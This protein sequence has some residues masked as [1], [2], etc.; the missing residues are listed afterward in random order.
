MGSQ[1][2]SVAAPQL[3]GFVL[4][5][6]GWIGSAIAAGL[7][8]W[9]V[10]HVRSA[11]ITSGVAW[12]GIWR[13]CFFSSALTTPRFRMMSCQRMGALD[14]FV[15][16]EITVAQGLM[17]AA[18]VAGALGKAAT[19]YGLRNVYFGGERPLRQIKVALT[20]GGSLHLLACV[21]VAIPAAWNLSS[22]VSNRGI[23]F[24]PHFHLPGSPWAQE[25][26]AAVYVAIF[27]SA[28][29]LLAGILLVSYRR[30]AGLKVHPSTADADDFSDDISLV[31]GGT[32]QTESC[33]LAKSL[34]EHSL[35]RHGTDNRA[36]SSEDKL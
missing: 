19:V 14:A 8:Q 11:A 21:C 22:V 32:F 26:G 18:V 1:S 33:S 12:V 15:P 28:L 23:E 35:S 3:V 31:S 20:A 7:V 2:N 36:F 4:G 25:A 17:L 5:V 16:L 24:P 34:S 9:R 27:S 6:V 29:L 30:P 13:V 10:W